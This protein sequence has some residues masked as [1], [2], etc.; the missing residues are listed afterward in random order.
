M[1]IENRN[2]NSMTSARGDVDH[3]VA[4]TA[5]VSLIFL[6]ESGGF[7]TSWRREEI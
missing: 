2:V 5:A 4:A 3:E 7:E 6:G 1:K